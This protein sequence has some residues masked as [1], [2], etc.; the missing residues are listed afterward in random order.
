MHSNPTAG[1]HFK[2]STKT[3]V[4][5]GRFAPSPTGSLHLGSLF[6]A[7]ASYLDARWHQGKWL[8]RIEDIDPPR[9]ERGAVDSILFC[10]KQHG[11]HSDEA[12]LFQSRRLKAYSKTINKLNQYGYTFECYCRRK[13]LQPLKYQHPPTCLPLRR[14][15][16]QS[17]SIR[18]YRLSENLH[19]EDR[20]HGHQQNSNNQHPF[21][22]KRKDQYPAYHLA[23]VVDDAYQ[24]ITHVVRGTDLLPSTFNQVALQ[25]VLEYP[26]L[27][28][29]HLP[30]ICNP[31]GQK[32]SKQQQ[33]SAIDPYRPVE[34]LIQVLKM[35]NIH[36]AQSFESNNY[37]PESLLRQAINYWHPQKLPKRSI[38]TNF[39]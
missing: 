22:I 7:V 20:L 15:E 12:I 14:L 39:R 37:T 18:F 1:S 25:Q 26:T 33:A 31:D 35:L 11:L 36:L 2:L 5:R 6:T 19:F 27:N 3:S 13:D 24:N 32:L 8:V 28:Y 23:V 21:I 9:M 29:L 16:Q 34:N 17:P 10:L 38:T 4:Y 30:L